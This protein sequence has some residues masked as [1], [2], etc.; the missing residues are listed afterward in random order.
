[1]PSASGGIARL[2]AARTGIGHSIGAFIEAG[3]TSAN[4]QCSTRL[5]VRSQIKFLELAAVRGMIFWVSF[6]ALL[7]LREIGLFIMSG[8]L[9]DFAD[10]LQKQAL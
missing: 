8:I 7:D 9:R 6:G 10:A 1:M 2:V 5:K 4:R 3:L